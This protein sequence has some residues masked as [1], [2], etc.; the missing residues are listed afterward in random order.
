MRPGF[1]WENSRDEEQK[2]G[3]DE[4]FRWNEL[5]KRILVPK[6]LKRKRLLSFVGRGTESGDESPQ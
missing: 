4:S 3:R 1:R 5:G 6:T 2:E